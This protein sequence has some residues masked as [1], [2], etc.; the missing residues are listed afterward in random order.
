MTFREAGE[1]PVQR[2]Q[3]LHGDAKRIVFAPAIFAGTKRTKFPRLR[4]VACQVV[5]AEHD[6]DVERGTRADVPQRASEFDDS[7]TRTWRIG[8]DRQQGVAP[9]LGVHAVMRRQDAN[10]PERILMVLI[11]VFS[12]AAVLKDDDEG[13]DCQSK[14]AGTR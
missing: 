1:N 7:E 5:D 10:W 12:S 2:G 3:K 4:R 13:D 11:G 9:V 14:G 6:A 8:A